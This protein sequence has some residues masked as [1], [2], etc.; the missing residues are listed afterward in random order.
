MNTQVYVCLPAGLVDLFTDEQ[1][2]DAGLNVAY[3]VMLLADPLPKGATVG[4]W[5]E[6]FMGLKRKDC[7]Q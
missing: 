2:L 5:R 6:K 3:V 4:E 7:T 1:A